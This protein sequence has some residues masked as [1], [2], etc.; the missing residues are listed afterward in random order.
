MTFARSGLLRR[1]ELLE[2]LV[3]CLLATSTM[4][5]QEGTWTV[6]AGGGMNLLQASNVNATL[7]RTVELWN[8]IEYIPIGPFEHFSRAPALTARAMYRFERDMAFEAGFQYFDTKVTNEYRG[9]RVYL[10]LE[11]T[12]GATEIQFGLSY[13][14]PPLLFGIE[15]YASVDLGYLFARANANTYSTKTAK[16]SG[17]EDSTYAFYD[18]QAEFAKR[19]L[20][21]NVGAGATAPITRMFIV[22]AECFYKYAPLGQ[23]DGEIRRLV[24]TSTEP[25]ATEFDFSMFT[26]SLGVGITF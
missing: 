19:K 7:D 18:T 1:S 23:M 20:V 22:R 9:D 17:T 3:A 21:L 24:G 12:L 4:L 8:N 2:T 26:L 15:T 10:F 16:L 25:S 5:A 13:F 6:S 11:R 14:F